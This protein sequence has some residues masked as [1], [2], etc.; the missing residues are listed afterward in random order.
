MK[1]KHKI[2]LVTSLCLIILLT[3]SIYV[4]VNQK[5]TSAFSEAINLLNEPNQKEDDEFKGKF[6]EVLQ[7]LF[8]NRNIA[9][10]NND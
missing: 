5:K 4:S 1:R 3:L 6:Q 10:L 9:I 2:L 7:E 8:K